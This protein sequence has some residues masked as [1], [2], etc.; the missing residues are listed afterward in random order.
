MTTPGTREQVSI[1][2]FE[3]LKTAYDFK[4]S[5]RRMKMWDQLNS[6][7]EQPALVLI[8][9]PEN[10]RKQNLIT[11]AVRTLSYDAYVFISDGLN[12]Q[13]TPISTLNDII[14]AIDPTS[15]G[16]LKPSN[17]NGKQTLGG[18][19]TDCY[20]EGEVVKV[21]GDLDGKGVAII[22]IRVLYM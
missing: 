8:E 1:A 2:L 3:L 22:P 19:V 4:S 20:I 9:I 5:W 18:L 11:P 10:H 12:Q 16:V 6:S 17:A 15:G 13:T 14:D 7:S 21:P